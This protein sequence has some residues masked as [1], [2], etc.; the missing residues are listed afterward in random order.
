MIVEQLHQVSSFPHDSCLLSFDLVNYP[1]QDQRCDGEEDSDNSDDRI[2]V[3]KV[4]G[5][6]RR[7]IDIKVLT[8]MLNIE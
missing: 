7:L 1:H 5:N 6:N 8:F 3:C 2:V 4:K